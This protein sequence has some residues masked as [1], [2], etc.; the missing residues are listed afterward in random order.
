VRVRIVLGVVLALVGVAVV[1]TLSQRGERLAGTS[2]VPQGAY[3]VVL[4]P[5]ATAC[6]RGTL[7]ADDSAAAELLVGTYGRPRPV[8][9]VTFADA[10]GRVIAR[11]QTPAQDG[12][13][14]VT[15]DLA[16]DPIEGARSTTA[17]VRNGGA[18]QVA[19]AGR[20]ADPSTAARIDDGPTGGV[21]GF[22]Y[23]R[24][25]R[26]SWWSLAPVV[27]QRFG[28]GKASALGTWTLPLVALALMGLWITAARLLLR[29]TDA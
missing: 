11:G 25:G 19:L 26:E 12:Q 21:A 8:L 7:L 17:C 9:T 20:V 16:G 10:Q 14:V 18:W 1:V 15:A 24:E 27:A 3:T 6:Q 22:R 2:F 13:G 23:L 5:H 29:E 28:L 4:P